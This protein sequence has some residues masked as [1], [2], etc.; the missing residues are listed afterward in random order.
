MQPHI[1]MRYKM[2]DACEAAMGPENI[3][4][5]AIPIMNRVVA[6]NCDVY[7]WKSIEAFQR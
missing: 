1:A 6:T 4:T 7:I 2:K 3:Q 5:T